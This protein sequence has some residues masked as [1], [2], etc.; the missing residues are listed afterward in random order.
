MLVDDSAVV[1]GLIRRFVD[2]EPGIEIVATAGD[3]EAAVATL[4]RTA[5]VDVIVLNIEMPAMDGL[6]TIPLLLEA[7]PG[8]KIVM[9]STL[10]H[11]QSP[12]AAIPG[13]RAAFPN[14][15]NYYWPGDVPTN[16]SGDE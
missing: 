10:T 2:P 5:D 16:G 14:A 6:T 4:K 9:A 8:V 7:Q 12:D 3:G 13:I 1:R 15:T 11:R